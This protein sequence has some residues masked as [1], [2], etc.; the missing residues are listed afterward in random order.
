MDINER[1]CDLLV[2]AKLR[3]QRRL[4][5]VQAVRTTM[6]EMQDRKVRARNVVPGRSRQGHRQRL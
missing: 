6:P 1:P 4:C 5:H 3:Y 2:R